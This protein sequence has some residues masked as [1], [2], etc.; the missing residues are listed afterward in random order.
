MYDIE[1]G[2][3]RF[4]TKNSVMSLQKKPKELMFT[5]ITTGMKDFLSNNKT[6]GWF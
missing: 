3:V 2:I 6:P 4:R 1:T 5:M